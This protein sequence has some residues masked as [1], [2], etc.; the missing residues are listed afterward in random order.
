M[1]IHLYCIEGQQKSETNALLSA[2]DPMFLSTSVR[3]G[4]CFTKRSHLF[5]GWASVSLS[6]QKDCITQVNDDD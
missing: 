4:E 3:P 2:L 5:K 6:G 1:F